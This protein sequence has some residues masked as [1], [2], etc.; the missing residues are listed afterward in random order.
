MSEAEVAG[1]TEAP[2]PAPEAPVSPDAAPEAASPPAVAATA[3]VP[4]SPSSTDVSGDGSSS[5]EGAARKRRRRGSRGGRKR[6]KPRANVEAGGLDPADRAD[7]GGR[8]TSAGKPP[9]RGGD[10]RERAGA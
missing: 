10:P 8:G 4:P 6:S 1:G 7:A 5:G 3:A 9:A 2:E